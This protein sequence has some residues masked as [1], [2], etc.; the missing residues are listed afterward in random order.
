MTPKLKLFEVLHK[1]RG[2]RGLRMTRSS[3]GQRIKWATV[4][5][6]INF[7]CRQQ[8]SSRNMTLASGQHGQCGKGGTR[9]T[10]L[11]FG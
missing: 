9:E 10:R 11:R 3:R 5:S 2:R 6:T 7:R 1:T 8:I 4:F